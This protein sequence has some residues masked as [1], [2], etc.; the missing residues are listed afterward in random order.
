MAKKNNSKSIET[1]NNV[2]KNMEVTTMAKNTN[3]TPA[4]ANKP[5][6]IVTFNIGNTVTATACANKLAE[7]LTKHDN[8]CLSIALYG[9]Y[10]TGVTIPAYYTTSGVLTKENKLAEPMSL[11]EA[12]KLPILANKSKATLSRCINALKL[13]IESESDSITLF[14]SGQHAFTYDKIFTYYNNKPAMESNGINTLATA[15]EYSARTLEK[16][17]RDWKKEQDTTPEDTTPEPDN[18]ETATPAEPAPDEM[19]EFIYNG[20]TYSV[21]AGA[22]EA[23]LAQAVVITK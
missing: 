22:M 9:A 13:V 10:M 18:V 12:C 3:T 11:A 17:V 21:R 4:T 23:L 5:A 19:V 14:T 20:N 16:L 1:T 6:S 7:L 8:V 15:M 2:S